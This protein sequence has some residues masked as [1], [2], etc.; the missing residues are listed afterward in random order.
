MIKST[1]AVAATML[2]IAGSQFAASPAEA[3]SWYRGGHQVDSCAAGYRIDDH[4]RRHSRCFRRGTAG[5]SFARGATTPFY[6]GI[7]DQYD[8]ARRRGHHHHRHSWH[9]S[10]I[11]K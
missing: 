5:F 2:L 9:S 7:T 3:W 1:A 10:K 8:G 4:G 11:A 6:A